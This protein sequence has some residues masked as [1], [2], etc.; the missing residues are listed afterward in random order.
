MFVVEPG[1]GKQVGYASARELGAAIRRGELGPGAR[2]YHR[3]TDRWLPITVHPEYRRAASEWER[4]GAMELEGRQWTFL[5]GEQGE[6]AQARGAVAPQRRARSEG[7]PAE[8][9]LIPG[10][11]QPSW[12][13]ATLRRLRG[14]THL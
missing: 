12:L 5:S 3:S 13:G 7:P 9:A 8:P 1:Q 11:P 2:I 10:D 14:L 4:R 6:R